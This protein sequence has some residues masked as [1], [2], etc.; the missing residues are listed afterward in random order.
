[1]PLSYGFREGAWW[2]GAGCFRDPVKGWSDYGLRHPYKVS[3]QERKFSKI[4][5]TSLTHSVGSGLQDDHYGRHLTY[6]LTP[7]YC[8]GSPKIWRDSKRNGRP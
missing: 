2:G 4:L 5:L 6:S 1:M 7:I 8:K 3:N